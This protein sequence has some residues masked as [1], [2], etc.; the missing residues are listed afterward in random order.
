MS[1]LIPFDARGIRLAILGIV[2]ITVAFV[3]PVFD[4]WTRLT[5]ANAAL[6]LLGMIALGHDRTVLRPNLVGLGIGLGSA[7]M[8]Y[9]GAWLITRL[10]LAASQTH[11]FIDWTARHSTAFLT[12]T[13][14]VAVLGEELFWRALLQRAL[15]ERFSLAGAAAVSVA[16]YAI[17]HLAS[18]TWLLPLAALGA[19]TVWTLAFVATGNLT[20][21][22][23]S[24]LLFD[25]LVVLIAPPA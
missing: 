21:S 9:G 6:A 4:V 23:V 20:A 13:L 15:R 24:H 18:G 7:A 16:A 19:G 8:L 5:I 10:P 1:K 14:P 22:I 17:A 3:L 2:V 12:V 11:L 25:V